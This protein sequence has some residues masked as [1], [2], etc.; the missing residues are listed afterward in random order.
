MSSFWHALPAFVSSAQRPSHSPLR[1]APPSVLEHE[2]A[3]APVRKSSSA[4]AALNASSPAV[5]V[6]SDVDDELAEL[7]SMPRLP[8]E[9]VDDDGSAAGR[10]SP[11][12]RS[13]PPAAS[14]VPRATAASVSSPLPSSPMDHKLAHET[15]AGPRSPTLSLSRIDRSQVNKDLD[16]KGVVKWCSWCF[17]YAP[18]KKLED[19]WMGRNAHECGNCLNETCN[20][21]MCSE[22]ACRSYGSSADKLCF[23]CDGTFNKAKVA[24]AM[25]C[26]GR[27]SW[28]FEKS[29]HT[30]HKS[31]L[32]LGRDIYFCDACGKRTV[33]CKGCQVCFARGSEELD[34]ELCIKCSKSIDEWETAAV[35]RRSPAAQRVAIVVP[36]KGVAGEKAEAVRF[37]LANSPRGADD[38]DS[39]AGW[40]SW[41]IEDTKHELISRSLLTRNTYRCVECEH[42]TLCCVNCEEGMARSGVGWD[43]KSCVSCALRAETA[44]ATPPASPSRRASVGPASKPWDWLHL[45]E[46]KDAVFDPARYTHARVMTLLS[47]SS[48]FKERAV[49]DGLIRPFLVLVSMRPSKR[50]RVSNELGWSCI[51]SPLFGDA[52]AESWEILAASTLG[53]LS[54]LNSTVEKLNPMQ[55]S[56]T[57]IECLE[58]VSLTFGKLEAEWNMA[59]KLSPEGCVAESCKPYS[60][61]VQRQEQV[62]MI[63]IGRLYYKY[64]MSNHLKPPKGDKATAIMNKIKDATGL[65]DS[66]GLTWATSI[67]F[68]PKTGVPRFSDALDA[69]LSE[70]DEQAS[71]G[72][73]VCLE[74]IKQ[75]LRLYIGFSVFVDDWHAL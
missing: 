8:F 34:E 29:S 10:S 38:D 64:L 54:R 61:A 39:V 45:K 46:K 70:R 17:Q 73:L 57:W 21:L 69:F 51:P 48:P 63:R 23:K 47:L 27:C 74:I 67:F 71:R 30:L 42:R 33:L 58:R 22:G 66:Y 28:C 65:S 40:C 18:Q 56:L 25:K 9:I 49:R 6:A 60:H 50:N 20:C 19:R 53:L 68:K 41:C 43:D 72:V 2:V 32:M 13:P 24:S 35:V 44:T 7:M 16:G 52:H 15:V 14:Y 36:E 62:L 37:E 75:L 5:L 1:A 31:P 59:A 55:R 4:R 26:D 12:S 11:A 3:V